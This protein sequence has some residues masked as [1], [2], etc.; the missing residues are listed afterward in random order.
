MRAAIA[1]LAACVLSLGVPAYA[2]D[3]ARPA[4]DSGHSQ[5]NAR[6]GR[7][8]EDTAAFA[9]QIERDLAARGARLAIVFRTGR[10]RKDLPEGISYTHGAFWV[11]GE[12]AGNDGKIYKGYAVY[13]LYQGDGKIQAVT[14]STLKQDFPIDFVAGST[15]DDVAVIIPSPE[16]QRR[17][18]DTIDSPVYEKMHVRS[19]TLVSNP[20]D[21]AHQNCTE[22]VLDVIAAAAW[23]TDSYSQVKANLRANFRPT[24]VRASL[25]QVVF[26]PLVDPRLNL[27]DQD[28][29]IETATYESI[30]A[31][32]AQNH[33]MK[34][35]YTL[36][37]VP[38]P[39]PS[40]NDWAR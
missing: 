24:I 35:T 7:K 8:P 18:I 21:P 30:T 3:S 32:M 5:Q 39:P 16:M 17:L 4:A 38:P 25:F 26:G 40:V 9:K 12:I 28:G 23:Q 19:Y 20:F 13:N 36:N 34:E 1:C 22:F 10:P 37:R 11:Y 29:D 27:D 31:F 14:Q 2:Q 6:G 33:L 15:A